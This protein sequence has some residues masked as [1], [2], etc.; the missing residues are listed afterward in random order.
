MRKISAAIAAGLGVLLFSAMTTAAAQD[1]IKVGAMV[2]LTGGAVSVVGEDMRRGFNM[3]I[4]EANAKGGYK[5]KKFEMVV[6]D[7]QANPTVGVGL[8]QRLLVR[9]NV[10]AIV[11]LASST[12][13]KAVGSI[14]AQHKKP[15]FAVG[16]SS[17]LVEEAYGKEPWFFHFIPWEYAR[18][19]T[20]VTVLK[21]LQ[22]TPKTVAIAYENGVYGSGAAPL[23]KEYMEAAGFTVVAYESFQAG[24]PSLL[25]LLSKLKSVNPEVFFSI[26]FPTDH[27]LIVKQSREVDFSPKLLWL[28]E[29]FT[30][31]DYGG[32]PS[33]YFSGFGTWI[34]DSSYPEAQRWIAEF[35]KLNPDR[36]DPLD[37]APMSYTAMKML[38]TAIADVG[39]DPEALTR[40]LERE[41]TDSPFGVVSFSDSKNGRH[42][43]L[44]QYSL[45]QLQNGKKVIVFPPALASAKLWYPMPPWKERKN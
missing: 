16:G 10:A 12:V 26:A 14:A 22:P 35:R 39:P 18:A 1:T 8:A 9:D 21:G 33:D 15:L 38:L 40:R 44:R 28:P 3:A 30:K 41:K 36:Q 4:G 32:T 31:A 7:D 17:P 27:L 45:I 11:G 34:A 37:W 6:G 25:P 13:I 20:A 5:G 43:A 42:Q 2:S 24:S 19:E 23:L 29:L